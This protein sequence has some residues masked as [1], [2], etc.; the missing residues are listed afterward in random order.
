LTQRIFSRLANWPELVRPAR[1]LRLFW[2]LQVI[3]GLGSYAM[4]MGG[5]QMAMSAFLTLAF[6]VAHRLGAGFMLV[7]SLV[8]TLQVFRVSRLAPQAT[9]Q[10]RMAGKVPA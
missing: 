10:N 6:P 1:Y 8:L 3:L 4:E 7:A 9:T 2:I 5:P